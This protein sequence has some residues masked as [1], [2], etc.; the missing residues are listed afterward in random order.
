MP[1]KTHPIRPRNVTV[2]GMAHATHRTLSGWGY[3]CCRC[4]KNLLE[5]S[6]V[7]TGT[8][9]RINCGKAKH[10]DPASSIY[11][12]CPNCGPVPMYLASTHRCPEKK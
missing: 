11:F 3:W 5:A 2:A 1:T 6:G 4:N 10:S 8:F 9:A 7:C 12:H